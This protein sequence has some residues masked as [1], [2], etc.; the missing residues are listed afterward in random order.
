MPKS[1]RAS[2]QQS[3]PSHRT[4]RPK[5]ASPTSSGGAWW[6]LDFTGKDSERRPKKAKSQ[7]CGRAGLLNSF[8][9]VSPANPQ[10][11]DASKDGR[12]RLNSNPEV[13]R[14]GV[15]VCASRSNGVILIEVDC[16]FFPLVWFVCF[17]SVSQSHP[18]TRPVF[19]CLVPFP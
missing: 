9:T 5:A 17:R 14:V 19:V 11:K 8:C 7:K 13:A 6:A 3:E 18:L 4:G 15:C 1:K 12:S 10:K 2:P 16:R